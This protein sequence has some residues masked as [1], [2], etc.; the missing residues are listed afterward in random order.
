MFT[1]K[2]TNVLCEPLDQPDEIRARPSSLDKIP[3]LDVFLN[4]LQIF[5]TFLKSNES[6]Q[7]MQLRQRGKKLL[8]KI[9][10]FFLT[11][12]Q[13]GTLTETTITNIISCVRSFFRWFQWSFYRNRTELSKREVVDQLCNI[14][15]FPPAKFAL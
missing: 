3:L 15:Q 5:T 2:V 7:V 6:L 8:S 1:A 14:Q 13:I 12:I 9:R 11:H 4:L 10:I